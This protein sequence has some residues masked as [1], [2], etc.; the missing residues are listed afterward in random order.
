MMAISVLLFNPS[1]AAAPCGPPT[2][3]LVCSSVSKIKA[4]SESSKVTDEWK[5]RVRCRPGIMSS[6]W[7]LSIT[8]YALGREKES[9]AALGELIA[10]YHTTAACQIADVYAFRNQSDKAFKWLD[11]AYAQR[12]AGLI[13]TKVD[14]L[15]KSLHSDPR[16]AAF[17]K[18]LNLPT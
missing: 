2:S 9:D 11:R 15:L 8:Y 16:F 5:V 10:K 13:E 14:P 17:L 12:D 7:F 18:K 1:L 4:R 3:H 6:G